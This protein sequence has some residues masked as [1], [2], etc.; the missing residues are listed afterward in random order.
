MMMHISEDD[1]VEDDHNEDNHVE[2]DHV[3]DDHVKD[4]HD[5]DE[6]DSANVLMIITSIRL[7]R[8]SSILP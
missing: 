7:P 5:E 8:L 4:D 3:E 6:E 1:H 2:D